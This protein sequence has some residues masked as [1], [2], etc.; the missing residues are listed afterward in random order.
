MKAVFSGV[1][2]LS[3]FGVAKADPN[4][5]AAIDN[6]ENPEDY[7]SGASVSTSIAPTWVV[8]GYSYFQILWANL[9]L[10]EDLGNGVFVERLIGS[11]GAQAVGVNTVQ[12]SPVYGLG[13]IRVEMQCT[14]YTTSAAVFTTTSSYTA[15]HYLLSGLAPTINSFTILNSAGGSNPYE[16]AGCL[17]SSY[18]LDLI[19]DYVYGF[20]TGVGANF[21]IYSS[22][23]CEDP[24]TSGTLESSLV[25]EEF[26]G[27]NYEDYLVDVN[28]IFQDFVQNN[29][30]L[31]KIKFT[32]EESY[33]GEAQSAEVCVEI[34][35]TPSIT[36]FELRD[37]WHPSGGGSGYNSYP[38]DASNTAVN[39]YVIGGSTGS[40][41]AVTSISG[42]GY[43]YYRFELYREDAVG[44]PTPVSLLSNYGTNTAPNLSVNLQSGINGMMANPTV[45]NMTLSTHLNKVWYIILYVGHP[46]CGEISS[47]PIYFTITPFSGGTGSQF[48]KMASG[49]DDGSDRDINAA[50]LGGLGSIE[51]T[52]IEIDIFPQPATDILHF[53]SNMNLNECTVSIHDIQGRVVLKDELKDNIILLHSLKSSFYFITVYDNNGIL[54]Y[55]DKMIKQ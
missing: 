38:S 16:L 54:V 45:D 22:S 15:T 43:S 34:T 14:T 13:L 1:I 35:N 42:Q 32:L 33:C 20:T 17:S 27:E 9:Y 36:N 48:G 4:I 24:A 21:E 18:S 37:Q 50:V 30:G 29:T 12:F 19:A 55:K 23:S 7:C 41:N 39:P 10:Q 51:S 6:L 40:I 11:V 44:S 28:D 46:L 49:G 26:S 52:T 3:S 47:P 31:Y 5:Q 53:I 2:L 8:D 25:F